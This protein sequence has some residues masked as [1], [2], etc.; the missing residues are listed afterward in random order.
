MRPAPLML[1]GAILLCLGVTCQ[2]LRAAKYDSGASDTE[3]KI[4]NTAP[5]SGAASVYGQLGKASAAY[6]RKVNDEGGVNGRKI[7]FISLDDGYSPPK[8]VE[9]T[10]RL[11]EEEAVLLDFNPVGTAPNSAIQ[12]YMNVKQVPQLFVGSGAT[13]WGDP[14]HYH[15]SMGWNPSYETEGKIYAH[16]I[17]A[18]I[19]SPKIGILYQ[20]DDYGKDYVAGMKKGLGDRTGLIVAEQS[21]EVTD[22]T[23]DSQI[24]A[25]RNSGANVFFNVATPKFA[26]QAIKKIAEIGWKPVHFLNNVATTVGGVMQPAGFENS[27]GIIS[28]DYIKDADD[29]EW[30]SDPGMKD[31]HAWMAKYNPQG[32]LHDRY[33]VLG[34]TVS[35]LLVQVLKQCGDELTRENVMRQAANLHD[36]EL[37]LLLPGIK[38][39]TSPSDYHPL[40]QE[41]MQRFEGQRWVRFGPVLSAE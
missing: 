5:Y 30:A 3:I 10:R 28:A 27:Q 21:Y 9:Q 25:L 14:Q 35:M 39:N 41:Q 29:P 2:P 7:V 16:Y 34:Y 31:W 1:G 8:T 40:Q 13:K 11:V 12:Q 22:P 32:N 20:N 26:A 18:H 17:L 38:V 36:I 37:P 33:N 19:P 6:F 23:V 24:V 4:G 15:W